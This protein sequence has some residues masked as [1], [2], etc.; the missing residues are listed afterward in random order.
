[1][2]LTGFSGYFLK[3]NLRN[4]LD[5]IY[6]HAA[7]REKYWFASRSL[8]GSNNEAFYDN[9]TKTAQSGDILKYSICGEDMSLDYTQLKSKYVQ[10]PEKSLFWVKQNANLV[11]P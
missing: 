3:Q 9:H 11:A 2:V 6:A 10:M 1:M 4:I 7:V 8:L 5:P